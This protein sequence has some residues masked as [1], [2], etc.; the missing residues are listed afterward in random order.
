MP[1]KSNGVFQ[2]ASDPFFP[3]DVAFDDAISAGGD[4]SVRTSLHCIKRE[5][6]K[7]SVT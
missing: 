2:P 4:S 7:D 5:Q 1:I 3:S 6:K